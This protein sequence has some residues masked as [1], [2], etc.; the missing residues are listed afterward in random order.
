MRPRRYRQEQAV[1]PLL[2]TVTLKSK[3]RAIMLVQVGRFMRLEG[4]LK[5]SEQLLLKAIDLFTELWGKEN[6]RRLDACNQLALAIFLK[7]EWREA[8]RIQ[9]DAM[10]IWKRT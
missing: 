4:K 6:P 1:V 3:Q 2:E 5:E 10:E 9:Q 8:I 7:G